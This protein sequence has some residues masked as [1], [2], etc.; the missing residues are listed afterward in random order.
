MVS[1]YSAVPL[2]YRRRCLIAS[3]WS[4]KIYAAYLRRAV[5]A[6]VISGWVPSAAYRMDQI[7]GFQY[8]LH[9]EGSSL[10][11]IMW[12]LNPIY[13]GIMHCLKLVMSKQSS[14]RSMYTIW[15][16]AI[17]FLCQSRVTVIPRYWK[18]L[19]TGT[20]PSALNLSY[21]QLEI[22]ATRAKELMNRIYPTY[23]RT[24]IPCKSPSFPPKKRPGAE[25]K[26]WRQSSSTI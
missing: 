3:Q 10:A 2:R 11:C 1:V 22:E 12:C 6:Y 25:I 26:G 24:R 23:T 14:I 7:A 20:W 18:V 21:S 9:S 13:I 16:M 5:T 8:T 17:D 15:S 19:E 4:V